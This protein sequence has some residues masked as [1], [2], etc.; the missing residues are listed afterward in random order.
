MAWLSSLDVALFR[1]INQT[2][3][4]PWFDWLMPVL[5]GNRLFVPVL[6]LASAG[7]IWKWRTRGVL[8]VL[9]LLL[10]VA[11]GDP[12][13]ANTIKH[14]VA[15]PR[16]PVDLPDAILR[17]G[18]TESYSMPSSH[19]ANW[20]GGALVTF[21][22]FRRSWRFMVPLAAAVGFSRI[23]N[24]VHYPSDVLAGAI[25][26]AGYAAGGVWSCSALWQWCGARWFP[27]WWG[28]LPSLLNPDHR[29]PA[30]PGGLP[31]TMDQHWLRLGYLLILALLCFR[32]G[33]LASGKIELSEDEAY[34]WLWSKHLA[35][36]Y[37][38]KP[39][40][41]A[42]TQWLGTTIWGD[43]AF[44]VRFCSPLIAATIS[45]LLLRFLAR[46]ASAR[47][48]FWLV[49]I[50]AATPLP[51]VGSILMTIDPLSVLFWTAAMIS[52]WRA[53]R[54]D[55]T[56]HWLWTGLWLGLGFLSKYT[57][58]LQLLYWAVFFLLYPPAAKQL[59]R[60]G[61]W[62]ALLILGACTLPVL[63]WNQQNHW[64]TLTHLQSRA[65][66]EQAWQFRTN[67]FIDFT[68]A[69]MGLLNPIFFGAALWA[70]LAFWR[71]GR[72]NPWHLFLF[73]MGTPL[74]LSYWLFTARARVQ[75]NW[76]APA[77]VPM[78]CLMVIY[79]DAR[80]REGLRAVKGWLA[81]G[82]LSGL[83]VVIVLHD[84]NL[85]GKLTGQYLPPDKDP[86]TRV[87]GWSATAAVV[88][89]ERLAFLQEGTPVFIIG[90]HY[91]ITGLLSFYI[92]AAKTAVPDRPLVYYQSADKPENQFYFWR[93]YREDRRGQNAL[94]VQEFKR[95]AQLEPPPPRLTSEFESI[96]D[97][98]TR[99]VLH[100]GRIIH[101]IRLFGC[102]NLR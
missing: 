60:P 17:V 97:L 3:S 28:R 13:V 92:P 48:G 102:R 74:F 14:A 22:Y 77:I 100:R 4:N 73:S 43:T 36:S 25:L 6:L 33:Y 10:T 85:L 44:G 59:R 68:V 101:R 32:W 90:S 64:I 82:V 41:I 58:L 12:L 47:A 50:L 65:G 72:N 23:Y 21:I 66:L 51:A 93:G 75:P 53:V 95:G 81:G 55:S 20:F 57:A 91:G 30:P 16:P 2:L 89:Q 87:R 38:S 39:P 71:R 94:Y 11:L 26:G 7:L 80:W 46:E 18:L 49:L 98:G 19:T 35:L 42:Y 52:G 96:V 9:F 86:L 5:S 88:E 37:Y 24:G 15:R 61:P 8:C 40:L 79:W 67:F 29:P 54:D 27:L 69:E 62:L 1:F 63:V 34:Q 76:I 84:T 70:A 78:F 31:P 99:D 83:L 56:R 45:Y